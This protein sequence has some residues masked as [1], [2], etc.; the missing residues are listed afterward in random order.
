MKRKWQELAARF[1]ALARRERLMVTLALL[2]GGAFL[3]YTLLIEPQLVRQAALNKRITQMTDELSSTRTQLAAVQAKLKDPDAIN[4]AALQQGRAELAAL[5]T[6]LRGL[7]NSM[8]PPEKMQ[9]FL[10]SLLSKNPNLELLALRTLP[11]TTLIERPETAAAPPEAPRK[12]EKA[13]ETKPAAAA[14]AAAATNVY[15]HGVEIRIAGRYNDLLAYLAE[16]EHM[17]Q[18]IMW[19]RLSLATEQYPRNVM[20]L[21]V[22]TLS[23]DKLWLVV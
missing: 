2:F 3:G 19:N 20:T 1:D 7:E 17:P 4:R 13:P 10:E 5:D 11:P 8:V 23:L 14:A 9:A 21:T 15:K 22:Y 6:K 18:H 16:I 12:G